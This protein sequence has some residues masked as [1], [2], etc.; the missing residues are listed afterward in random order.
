MNINELSQEKE[1]MDNEEVIED[2]EL[3]VSDIGLDPIEMS[4][5]ENQVENSE[6]QAHFENLVPYLEEEDKFLH[7]LG[8]TVVDNVDED[9]NSRSALES[10]LEVGFQHLNPSTGDN[11]PVPFEGACTITHPLIRENA[12]K[13]QAKF[14][15]ALL[16]I[17]GPARIDIKESNDPSVTAKALKHQKR[18]N[19]LLRDEMKEFIPNM[20]S[21]FLYMPLTGT[22]IKKVY[23]DSVLNRPCSEFIRLEN[24]VISDLA[25]DFQTAPR[26]SHIIQVTKNE[27]KKKIAAG[28]YID[29]F[30]DDD[31]NV[32]DYAGSSDGPLIAQSPIV[33]SLGQS[34]A[35]AFDEP[36]MASS[37]TM[38]YRLIEQHIDLDMSGTDF[39]DPDGIA[40]PYVVTVEEASR[41]VLAI[42]R[43]W[44]EDDNVL[45]R[46]IVN[47]VKYDFVPGIGFYGQGFFHLLLDFQRTLTAIT[48]SLVDS[49][50][51]ANL[52]GGFRKKGIRL[53]DDK[54]P[55][56]PG[57]FRELD[58]I[59]ENKLGDVI[60]PL[61][62]KE[63][64]ATL[65]NMMVDLSNRGQQFADNAEQ[66]ANESVNYGKV[67]TTMALMEESQQFFSSIFARV[68]QSMKQELDLIAN[69]ADKYMDD[70][71]LKLDTDGDGIKDIGPA[72]DPNYPTRT[73][74][75]NIAQSKLNLALQAP[76]VHN[77]REA[78]V[79]FY[80]NLGMGDEQIKRILPTP[81]EAQ[82]QD[83]LTD[84][85]V[86]CTGGPIKAFPGQDHDAH[87]AVKTAFIQDPN[88]Q[89]FG[90][91]IAAIQANIRE[92]QLLKYVEQVKGTMQQM[93][94]AGEMGMAQA[95]QM[96]LQA[97]MSQA[98]G[99]AENP[100]MVYAQAEMK[101]AE[102]IE[103][104]TEAD[105]IFKVADLLNDAARVDVERVREQ[106]RSLEAQAK[107]NIE[108]A[109]VD[110][111]R[112][113]DEVTLLLDSITKNT[114]K[115]QTE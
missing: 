20:E 94:M 88:N 9:R 114:P 105:K 79:D 2:V 95:A 68:Y 11:S 10:T 37:E 15:K 56:R 38:I 64:S 104:K 100:E 103:S 87:M 39:E 43:N 23:F 27:L 106:N 60:M 52:Q 107:L 91:S 92:H 71:L 70:P 98:Q 69:L 101:K 24:F 47:F 72:T 16:P 96:V 51:F 109:K 102:A 3:D 58:L 74:K 113:Y 53:T 48:R 57:E 25:S 22:G 6:N 112:T 13:Y 32:I 40:R 54:G 84:I 78:F 29:V 7:D 5:L 90:S 77:L 99:G 17:D 14:S 1:P 110:D 28:I 12:V 41:K 80:Q 65:F 89:M 30:E 26:Y 97:N 61:P 55:L 50:S 42:R 18:F 85:Q 8:I 67:G 46:K 86:A 36:D 111:A 108:A 35:E 63:P 44:D 66:V 19:R 49:A 115:I 62:F 21:M 76:Q 82:P 34:E 73:H 4:E 45:K 75:L 31:K 81:A 59:G 83:P 33:S 93:Q